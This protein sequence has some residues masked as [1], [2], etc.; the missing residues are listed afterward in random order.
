MD[1]PLVFLLPCVI[2]KNC[3]EKIEDKRLEDFQGDLEMNQIV[4]PLI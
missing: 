2:M 3:K 1:G 4:D